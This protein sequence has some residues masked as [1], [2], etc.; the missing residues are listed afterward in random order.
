MFYSHGL[1]KAHATIFLHLSLR[2]TAFSAW[3]RC[4]WFC[5][6]PT[7]DLAAGTEEAEQL[8]Q[9]EAPVWDF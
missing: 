9:L 6:G 2:K 3:D 8:F 1:G 7:F 4:I 5:P